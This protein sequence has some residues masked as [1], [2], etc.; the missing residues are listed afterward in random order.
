MPTSILATKLHVPPPRPKVVVRVRLIERMNA[1]LR[2]KLTLVSAP[3]GFGKTTLVSEWIETIRQPTAWLSLDDGDND[4]IRFLTYFIAALQ[5]VAPTIGEGV[6]GV[7]QSSQPAPIESLLTALV[8][9]ITMLPDHFVLVLDDYHV[10][11]AVSVS[12]AMSF[13]LEYLPAQMHLVIT[14]RDDPQLPLAR[15]RARAQL[16]ELRAHD[17]RFDPS[18]AAEF[19]N[20]V[21]GLHL[22]AEQIAAL[23]ARTE[24]WI[25]G[26]QLAA[27]SLQ[28]HRDVP[29]F[30]RAFAGDHRYIVDYLVDEVLDHQPKSVRSFL[31]QTAILDRLNGSLCDAVTGQ[32]EGNA[33]LEALEKGNLFIIPL[34]NKRHW[35]RYHHLFADV[36]RRHLMTEQP[37]QV[38]VLHRRASE[39]LEQNGSVVDAIHHALA[40]KDFERAADLI[41]WAVPAIRRNR[42]ESTM[43][44]WLQVLPND[45]LQYRPVLSVHFV[46]ALLQ[47]GQIEG[48]EARLQDTERW[49][50][51]KSAVGEMVVVDEEEFRSLA[52]SVALYR[53]ACALRLGD[54]PGTMKHARLVP[55][56]VSEDDH[57]RRGAAAAL[58]GIASWT[59]GNLE[60]GHRAYADSMVM[61]Q[62]IGHFSDALGCAL[63]LADIQRAQGRLHEAMNTYERGLQIANEQGTPMLRGIADMY[64]GLS[65]IC[66]EQG[67]LAAAMQYLLSSKELGEFAGLPQNRYRW[68]V[69]IARIREIEGDLNGALDLLHEAEDVYAGDFSPNVR[70]VP[71][72]RARV[73]VMQGRLGEARSWA[74]EQGLSVEGDL[75]YLHEFE[76]ITHARILLAQYQSD[77]EDRLL[78]DII[79]LLDRLLRAAEDGG[80]MGS[81][82][83]ILILQ[84]LTCHMQGD[85]PAALVPLERALIIAE[86]E[87]YVRLFV[88]EGQ[89]MAQLLSAALARGIRPDYT[90]KLL[91]HFEFEM[92]H[93]EETPLLPLSSASQRLIE[94]LSQRELEVLRLVAQGL[95]NQEISERLFI[96]LVTVKVHNG[97]IFEK[98]HVRR[99]T[100][101]V[102]RARELGLL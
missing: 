62:R 23:E 10:I 100:E 48:V 46:G 22:A 58:L 30:I 25:A 63:T 4:P 66:R 42:Q 43:L 101:A 92:P 44:G 79:T 99:R 95:S 61:L 70:P 80:R 16:T 34:D 57:L 94:P 38:S 41:E 56:L 45:L 88:D 24:G 81:V 68:R 89:P 50:E 67:D 37:D 82:I 53:A 33:K 47:S 77:R 28:G 35:Y 75:S 17:L 3:A 9:E 60:A 96:A 55:D 64:V 26:L 40:A 74:R 102:A 29:A 97:K 39:W 65:E 1:G 78:H 98:L 14:T 90:A 49:L 12:D 87:G 69:A 59:T 18:E 2:G 27:L 8:N 76:Y 54:V 5:A 93:G 32:K 20:H 6:L 73:W 21:M 13:L 15:L 86:P 91:T 36:L 85:I 52:G 51:P 19:L 71:A 31:L 83:E 11:D 7:L 72:L 84:A